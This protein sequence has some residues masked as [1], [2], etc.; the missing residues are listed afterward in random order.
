MSKTRTKF[1]KKIYLPVIAYGGEC[2]AEY[3]MSISSLYVKTLQSSLDISFLSTGIFFESLVSR[4]RNAAAAA[5]LH[6]QSDY[7]LF[8]DA[9]IVF[10]PADVFKLIKHDKDV[11]SGLYPKKYLNDRKMRYIGE[12]HNELFKEGKYVPLVTDF[13]SEIDTSFLQKVARGD[14]LVEVGYAATGFM[15]IKRR[16]FEKIIKAKPDLK[17]KNEVDGYMSFGDN[18]YNFFPADINPSTRKYESE[19]YGFCNLWRS[20]GG[21][22]HVDPSINPHHMGSYAYEGDIKAQAKMYEGI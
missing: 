6:Y 12:H 3:A 17:Y 9:D 1:E 8:I 21:K 16:V 5:S 4:A 20:L 13:T 22:I 2:R 7:L 18:F 14:K 15:L 11:V 10:D 19:D